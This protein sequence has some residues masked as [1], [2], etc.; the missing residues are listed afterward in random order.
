MIAAGAWWAREKRSPIQ[1]RP[2]AELC[3]GS[4]SGDVPPDIPVSL[5]SGFLLNGSTK[6]QIYD[7]RRHAVS[8]YPQLIGPGYEPSEKIFGGMVDGRPWWGLEGVYGYGEGPQSVNG[9]SQQGSIIANPFLLI[10]LI[11]P[12]VWTFSGRWAD[13]LT[14]HSVAAAPTP[15]NLMWDCPAS[16]ASVIYDVSKYLSLTANAPDKLSNVLWME[17]YNARDL[18]F[19]YLYLDPEGSKNVKKLG[20]TRYP[21]KIV[22]RAELSYICGYPDGCNDMD[23]GGGYG[24]GLRVTALPATAVFKLWEVEQRPDASS[25]ADAM[26]TIDLR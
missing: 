24:M 19:T 1:T 17:S 2:Q 12:L 7:L 21:E 16:E 26:F 8:L 20:D 15:H 3:F 4:T 25:R 22:G 23:P 11:S 9:F 14:Q 6:R 18:G 5:A 10:G 13:Y